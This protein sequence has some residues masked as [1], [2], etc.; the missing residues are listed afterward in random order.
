MCLLLKY[1]MC[2]MYVGHECVFM[3]V[4]VFVRV[5]MY[6]CMYLCMYVCMYVCVCVC[7]ILSAFSWNKKQRLK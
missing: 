5:C 7:N 3:Y 4:Q 2:F 1:I 6:V